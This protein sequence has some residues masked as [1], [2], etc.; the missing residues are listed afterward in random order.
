MKGVAMLPEDCKLI[1][2]DDHIVEPPGLWQS[3]LP[4]K[5][6]D[7]APRIMELHADHELSGLLPVASFASSVREG[8]QGWTYEGRIYPTIGLSAVAGKR[9]ED[10]GTDPI[11][12]DD[13]RPGCYSIRERIADMDEDGVHAQLNFPTLPGFSGTMFLD[14]QDKQLAKLCVEAWND[15]MIDEWCSYSPG[16]QIPQVIVPLWDVE[17][18]AAEIRRTAAKGARAVTLPEN[19]FS[20]GLPS[21]HS[22]S[23]DPLWRAIDETGLVIS[24]HFGS[25]GAVP[26]TGDDMPAPVM[27]ASMA[28]NSMTA[29]HDLCFSRVFHEFPGLKVS[30]A[31]GGVGWVAYSLERMD[32]VWERHRHWTGINFDVRPSDLFREHVWVCFIDDMTGIRIR[33]MVGVDK[34]LWESD[35]PHSDG[36]WPYSR[37]RFDEMVTGVPE[38][39]VRKIGEENARRL[40]NWYD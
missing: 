12:F 35:Y 15:F 30:L 9:P 10:Y 7:A 23:W 11:R 2:V 31:E 27:I 22:D 16:R 5:Y 17:L 3:R 20:R 21:F 26:Y 36:T 4:Q 25:S 18:A 38:A 1:S 40:F 6:L 34:I 33:D 39:D 8:R 37:K 14:A 19:T 13:M 29:L 24:M 28:V 32:Y